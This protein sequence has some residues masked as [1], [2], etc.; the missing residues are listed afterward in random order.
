[1]DIRFLKLIALLVAFLPVPAFAIE[2]NGAGSMIPASLINAWSKEYSTR[3]PG[4]LIVYQGSTPAD[5]IKRLINNEVDFCTVDMPLNLAELDKNGLAQ[6]PLVL[7][8]VVPVVNLPNV[9][10]GQL[11]LDGKV[12]GDIFLGHI[13]KWNDPLIALLNPT[14]KLPDA[15]IV[16]VHRSSPADLST[17]IGDYLAKTHPEWKAVKGNTMAGVWPSTSIEVKDATE[18]FEKIKNTPYSIGYGPISLASQQGLTY[19]K[20]KNNAGNF[21]SPTDTSISEAATNSKW[22]VSNGFDVVLTDQPGASSWPLSMASFILVH[23]QNNHPERNREVLKFFK[24]NL[25]YGALNA[26]LNGFIQLPDV[27]KSVVRSSL[28]SISSD[29]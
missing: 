19:V 11:R 10:P 12:I 4:T 21:I 3:F 17:I 27:V 5:G 7:G 22:D 9:T 2:V 16:I 13:K 23:K 26:S 25:R 14:V 29:K 24:Y 18:N 28:D 8:A 1:M 20:M 15:D 6:F